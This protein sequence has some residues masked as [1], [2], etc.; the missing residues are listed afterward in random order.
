M[1]CPK[2]VSE[3]FTYAR[4]VLDEGHHRECRM[5]PDWLVLQEKTVEAEKTR[6][7]DPVVDSGRD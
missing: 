3:E 1:R 5:P 4:C 6:Q 7:P 2:L